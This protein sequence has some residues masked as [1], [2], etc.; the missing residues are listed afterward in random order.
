MVTA[1][2]SALQIPGTAANTPAD[3][4]ADFP[5][6]TP[7]LPADRYAEIFRDAGDAMLVMEKTVILDCNRAALNMFRTG[8][9]QL[10]GRALTDLYPAERRAATGETQHFHWRFVRPDS[11]LFDADVKLSRVGDLGSG[12]QI[13]VLRPVSE[14]S[15]ELESLLREHTGQLES[16][17][18]ELD[19]IYFAV[20]H[21]LRAAIRGIS[22]CSQIVLD[23]FGTTLTDEGKRWLV[24]IHD[25]SR[26]LDRLTEALLE[27]SHVSRA[28]LNPAAL[29][30]TAMAREIALGLAATAPARTVE[31]QIREGMVARGD[32]AL[33]RTLLRNLLDNAWKFTSKTPGA[34]IECGCLESDLDHMTFYIHDN[35]VGFNMADDERLFTAFQRLHRDEDFA[36]NGVG[37]A[38]VRRIAHRHGGKAW[39]VAEPGLGAT[40]FFTLGGR[41]I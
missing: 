3:G 4:T 21:D 35:G 22:A 5:P 29:D 14:N 36:G 41:S 13:A 6:H 38:T 37:L 8:R 7:G 26:Q 18:S 32:E 20:S 24:H 34:R 40:F 9:S 31:F 19:A 17:N 23:D 2:S 30:L 25:D 16:V 39:A 33:L 10:V 12:Y 28:V 27:L 11:T 15:V 1:K